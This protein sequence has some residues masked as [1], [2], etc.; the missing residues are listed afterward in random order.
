MSKSL[1]GLKKLKYD[2]EHELAMHEKRR[3]DLKMLLAEGEQITPKA[4][5]REREQLEKEVP[6]LRNERARMCHDLVFA[7]V[8]SYNKVNLERVEQNESR[9]QGRTKRSEEEL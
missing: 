7:E 4:W 3:T 1:N 5:R 6:I 2:K 8:I 9:Q